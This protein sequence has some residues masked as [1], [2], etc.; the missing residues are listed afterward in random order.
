MITSLLLLG[1]L[2]MG[3]CGYIPRRFEVDQ[4]IISDLRETG[5]VLAETTYKD[6]WNGVISVTS[7]L[8][9][10]MG[11]TSIDEAF[12]RAEKALRL[13][14]WTQVAEQ[15]PSWEQMESLRWKNVLLSISS[16]PFFEDSGGGGSPIGDAIE[17]ARARAS[18]DM[19]S[20]LVIEVSRTDASSE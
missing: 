8:I 19:K 17:L 6:T 13:R 15:L 11:A 16:L 3:G 7:V 14:K 18:G 5:T 12:K 9:I 4:V 1:A 10:D 20:A 2:V